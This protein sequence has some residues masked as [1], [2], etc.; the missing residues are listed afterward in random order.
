M[1]ARAEQEE[2]RRCVKL[3]ASERLILDR[4]KGEYRVVLYRHRRP[5]DTDPGIDKERFKALKEAGYL[6]GTDP[7]HWLRFAFKSTNWRIAVHGVL[8]NGNSVSDPATVVWY[9]EQTR[10]GSELP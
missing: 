10:W 1:G 3:G 5:V 9:I 6:T 4:D 8:D 7:K 2:L